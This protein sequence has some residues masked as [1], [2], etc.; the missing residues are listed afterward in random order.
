MKVELD[1]HA[2][3]T[4]CLVALYLGLQNL[5]YVARPLTQ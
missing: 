3:F 5:S 1:V 4:H 2:E